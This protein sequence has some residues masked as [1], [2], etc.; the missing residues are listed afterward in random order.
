[1][2][3]KGIPRI[4]ST[5]SLRFSDVTV[6]SLGLIEI[7][8]E[9]PTPRRSIPVL[10]DIAAV[11]IP[12]LLGLDILDSE[13]LYADNATNRLVHREVLSKPGESLQYGDR[14]QVPLTRYGS[15]LYA[16][17]HLPRH[18]FYTTKDLKRLHR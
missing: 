7:A 12:A 16:Q 4:R 6:P 18:T 5:N 15:H 14:W 8:L 9:V 3:K 13:Q 17:M 10:M 2:G 11:D 1:M